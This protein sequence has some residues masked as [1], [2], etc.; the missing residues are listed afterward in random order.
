[1]N[2]KDYLSQIATR[3]NI[4]FIILL[5]VTIYESYYLLTH[6]YSGLSLVLTILSAAVTF[7]AYTLKR[8]FE[9]MRDN[10]N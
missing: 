6:P 5:I 9:D 10:I 1:M 7:F 3:L 2:K 4:A 8:F